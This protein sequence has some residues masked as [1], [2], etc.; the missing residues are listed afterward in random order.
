[1]SPHTLNAQLGGLKKEIS[2][3]GTG[4]PI[5]SAFFDAVVPIV[6]GASGQ[7]NT[8][9]NPEHGGNLLTLWLKTDGGGDRVITAATAINAT[10]NNT[11]T[12]NDANDSITL[13]S[14]PSGSGYRWQEVA[15]KGASLSTV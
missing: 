11:I 3:P 7:T 5:V 4:T 2:D 10:G 15:N 6:T 8:L 9:P 14:V 1:M 13:M 12:M